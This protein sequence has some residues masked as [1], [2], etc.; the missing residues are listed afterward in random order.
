MDHNNL[1]VRIKNQAAELGFD[2]CGIIKV[3]AVADYA[4]RLED[5]VKTFPESKPLYGFTVK[6]AQPQK[7]HDWARSIIVLGYHYGKYKV[8]ESAEGL[9]GKYYLFDYKFQKY[10]KEFK[11]IALF[12]SFLNGLGLKTHRETHGVTAAR[13]A[14]MKAGLGVI[15]KNNF[16]YTRHG[17]WVILETW[18]TDQEM[19][20]HEEETL[21]PCP[22]NCTKCIDTC[23]TGALAEPYATNMAECISFLTWGVNKLVPEH[24]RDKMGK[25]FTD[26]MFVRTCVR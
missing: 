17:S 22:E 10:S 18:L 21:P 24:L 23:P 7:I 4:D 9:I 8:P 26:A 14:A 15:R 20:Y 19:E 16:F 11:N 25:C 1:A 13:W 3:D 5:R 12:E 2:L 6:F